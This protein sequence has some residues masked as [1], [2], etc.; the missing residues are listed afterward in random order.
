MIDKTVKSL[1]HWDVQ[2]KVYFVHS[3]V[4]YVALI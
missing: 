3:N 4:Q 1:A 2:V